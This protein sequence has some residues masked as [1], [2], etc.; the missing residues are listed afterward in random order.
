MWPK[1][2]RYGRYPARLLTLVLLQCLAGCAALGL[3]PAKSFD[4]QLAYA[5]GTYTAVLQATA[6]AR[7]AGTLK[8]SDVQH[9]TAA[10]DQVRGLLDGARSV[11]TTNPKGAADRL[12]LAT[13][14]LAELQTWLHGK[15]VT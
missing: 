15:G 12:H 3:A 1:C 2:G 10:A 13:S 11:E 8:P 9:V 4:E 6:T 5:Y 14:I 7:D